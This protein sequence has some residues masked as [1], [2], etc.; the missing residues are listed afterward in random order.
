VYG[1]GLVGVFTFVVMSGVEVSLA[2]SGIID[3]GLVRAADAIGSS[4]AALPAAVLGLLLFHLVGLPWL[5]FGLVRA[6]E[7]PLLVAV[8]ATVGTGCAFFGSG[9]RV[10]T[11]GWVVSGIALAYLGWTVARSVTPAPVDAD[12]E[13]LAPSAA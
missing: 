2:T 1:A 9:T 12:R 11:V 5:T 13:P 4:P 6:R 8:L 7:L 10:E 3:D